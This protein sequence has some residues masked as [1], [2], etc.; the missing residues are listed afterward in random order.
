MEYFVKKSEKW[1][2]EPEET[3]LDR[4]S[5]EKLNYAQFEKPV[6]ARNFAALFVFTMLMFFAFTARTAYLA[7]WDGAAYVKMAQRNKT[8][9][10]PVL[11]KR[12]IIYDRNLA[13]LVENVPSFDVVVVPADLPRAKEER[14]TLADALADALG[15]PQAE[16]R[17][18]FA[19]I[20]LARVD[21]V[22]IRDNISRESALFF[23][24][25]MHRFS[26]VEVKKNAVRLYPQAKYL[27]QV[28]GYNGRVSEDD[29]KNDPELFAIDTIGKAGAELAY[30]EYLRGTNGSVEREID[31]VS[32][33][34]KEKQVREGSIGM[35][36]VLTIDAALQ[37]K[38]TDVLQQY[39]AIT[40][41][42]S[43]ASAAAIDPMTGEILALVSIPSYDNNMFSTP[44]AR[45]AYQELLTNPA[46][47]F[48]NRA[49]A[50]MYPPGSSIKPFIAYAALE[51]DVVTPR[52]KIMSAGAIVVQNP[53]NPDAP[54]IFR[55]WK[56]GG[57]GI[58]DVY[59][60]IAESVNTYFYT[61][62]GGYGDIEGLG[63]ARIKKYLESFGFGTKTN[64]DIAGEGEGVVPDKAWKEEVLGEQ[65]TLGDTYNVSIGQGNLLVTPLQLARA[66]AALAN[67][68]KLMQPLLV[69]EVIDNNKKI[70]FESQPIVVAISAEDEKN[71][72]VVR[73]A[74]RQAVTGGSARRLADLSVAV[75]GKTG[76]AQA[77]RG[78]THAWF[79]SF[80]PF[81]DPQIALVILFEE[82][83]EGSVVAVPAAR[84][85]YQ[86]YFGDRK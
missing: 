86:W 16:M 81:E 31:S 45:K 48:F 5:A 47:P 74:M 82:G 71:L 55:D 19:R 25:N 56:A 69:K 29:M 44:T 17:A 34:M 62:G 75:A 32:R 26:G 3:L 24:T 59:S 73:T 58:V 36:V 72:S 13:P 4:G 83:G 8:R 9:S 54:A 28:L 51:E 40:P 85:I 42:A 76:T 39:L 37:K 38:I 14:E 50:G 27:A 23:E 43:G 66:Y 80:A 33:V 46:N 78:A 41:E 10:Y 64:A 18:Q 53:Y 7:I 30:D 12:G 84:E 15:V 79:S 20:N 52:T 6:S 11:A 70:I 68:G 21:P 49:I 77:Q 67:G 60:A 22:L 57:H 1:Q 65:W 63:I 2:I 61:V 35:N